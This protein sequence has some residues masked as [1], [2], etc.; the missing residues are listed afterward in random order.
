M[1]RGHAEKR[2]V[3]RTGWGLA[4]ALWC[5][6]ASVATG[7]EPVF[8]PVRV[9]LDA[10]GRGA[11]GG[12][13]GKPLVDSADTTPPLGLSDAGSCWQVLVVSGVTAGAYRIAY[14]PLPETEP[15]ALRVAPIFNAVL[16]GVSSTQDTATADVY[17][18]A[19]PA[20]LL[21]T[22]ESDGMTMDAVEVSPL[23]PGRATLA[24]PPVRNTTAA[25]VFQSLLD[26]LVP[27]RDMAASAA[28]YT[29]LAPEEDAALLD[30]TLARIFPG[31]L[32]G[33]PQRVAEGILAY[34]AQMIRLQATGV[35]TGSAVL[36]QGHA[37][38]HGMALAYAALCRRAGLPARVNALYNFGLMQSHN[39]VEVFFEDD[40]HLY[41]PTY[42]TLFQWEPL[43]DRPRPSVSLQALMAHTVPKVNVVQVD[44]PIASGSYEAEYG[45]R[46]VPADAR[47]AR[48]PF[49]L[50]TFYEQLFA[51][52]MPVV[53]AEDM[54]AVFPIEL[55]LRASEAVWAGAVDGSPEDQ[56]G[57]QPDRSYRRFAG[58]PALGPM[59]V[60]WGLHLLRIRTDGPV[61]CRIALHGL[62][63]STL[64]ALPVYAL[65]GGRVTRVHGD[66]NVHVIECRL[67]GPEAWLLLA[68]T[69]GGLVV[70]AYQATRTAA[71][72]TG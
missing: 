49:P 30:A 47:Y 31:A 14:M 11:A 54:P 23:S 24:L 72:G 53:W 22:T 6:I 38:C 26:T 52:A 55:D 32:P 63:G 68:P 71:A 37:F 56:F 3:A 51:H 46:V 16:A 20:L 70:D 9:D 12:R 21:I 28:R 35:L 65:A 8:T 40:W 7:T 39:M 42:G 69:E 25:S 36:A 17:L 27:R 1:R 66:G 59:A 61:D 41:D 10:T 48:W 13:D 45:W 33:E 50:Q 5:G 58:A 18:Q 19:D 57:R 60:G 64:T 2:R 15:K 43:A 34:C 29:V 44:R 67:G 62:P 4:V